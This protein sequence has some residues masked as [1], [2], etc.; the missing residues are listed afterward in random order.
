[1]YGCLLYIMHLDDKVNFKKGV[2]KFT[3]SVGKKGQNEKKL[4]QDSFEILQDKQDYKS[5]DP[6]LKKQIK[7]FENTKKTVDKLYV[8]PND[9]Y[10]LQSEI[11]QI[12]YNNICDIVTAI[13][14]QIAVL[15]RDG[16]YLTTN[17]DKYDKLREMLDNFQESKSKFVRIPSRPGFVSKRHEIK[18]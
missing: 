3:F 13:H 15:E 11:N 5:N 8:A 9:T 10:L 16:S 1:M 12:S 17:K 7:R 4:I 6:V 14:E 18:K 2:S